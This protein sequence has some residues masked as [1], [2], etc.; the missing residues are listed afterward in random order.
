MYSLQTRISA[1]FFNFHSLKCELYTSN[2]Q[3]CRLYT[4]N[5]RLYVDCIID[6]LKCIIDSLKC[7]IDSLKC[8]IDSL[9][10]MIDSL[11]CII[12][13]LK[14]IIDTLKCGN[15]RNKKHI[16]VALIRFRY[17]QI[18]HGKCS[19]LCPL[20][21]EEN[22]VIYVNKLQHTRILKRRQERERLE[23]A[24]KIPTLRRTSVSNRQLFDCFIDAFRQKRCNFSNIHVFA[25]T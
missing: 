25:G 20:H 10:C 15:W 4:S 16:Y 22:E 6:S 2:C 18:R 5:R 14:C 24:G 3:L 21:V 12:D 8:I 19:F 7:I 13:S 1:T 11:K 9:K 23:K 17:S